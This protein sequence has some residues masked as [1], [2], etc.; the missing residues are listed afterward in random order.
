[1]QAEELTALGELKVLERSLQWEEEMKLCPQAVRTVVCIM[2][3]P[4]M[5]VRIIQKSGK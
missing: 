5:E 4:Y 1:M 2:S 3:T